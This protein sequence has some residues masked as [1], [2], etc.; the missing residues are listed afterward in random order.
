MA[1][2]G[3]G[4]S[5][6][7]GG[8]TNNTATGKIAGPAS[9]TLLTS[10]TFYDSLSGYTLSYPLQIAVPTSVPT[11]GSRLNDVGCNYRYFYSAPVA[12]SVGTD[13]LFGSLW[14]LNNTK[15]LAP[16]LG[17]QAAREFEDVR[18]LSAWTSTKGEGIRVA[19]IDDAIEITHG[20]L[21]PNVEPF[22]SFDYSRQTPTA[23]PLPCKSDETH[24]TAVAG[25]LAARDNNSVGIAGV[26]P[27]VKMSAFN[28]L[29]N[30]LDS[31]IA[32]ALNREQAAISIYH[33]SWGSADNGFLHAS[34]SRY[35]DAIYRGVR[36]GRGGKGSIYV[37]PAGNG[38]CIYEFGNSCIE[39]NSNFDA[40]VNNPAVIAVCAVDDQGVQPYYGERG[41]NILVCA[42]SSN[43]SN[44]NAISTLAVNNGTITDFGGTSASTPMVSGVIALMLS[45][46]PNLTWRDVRIILAKTARKN[47]VTDSR[48]V[49]SNRL[50]FNDKYGFG[51]V[52]AQAAVAQAKTWASV[53]TS[54][55]LKVCDSGYQLVNLSI[56]DLQSKSASFNVNCPQITKIEFIE[57]VFSATHEYSG[58]LKIELTSPSLTTS[59][60]ATPRVCKQ[61]NADGTLYISTQTGKSITLPCGDYLDWT[62]GSVR[63][64]EEAASGNWTLKVTDGLAQGAGTWDSWRIKIHGR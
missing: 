60:L 6:S 18:A 58:D 14:H 49:T 50:N 40:Y 1:C 2:G 29:A 19:V 36:L 39:E 32:D 59:E 4:G 54:T 42:P 47:D 43:Y 22:T 46:N 16:G 28:A 31:D 52:D 37:F 10:K 62:F 27:R 56:P 44:Q 57:V 12:A 11:A 21:A 20:D 17:G 26:S 24:G 51:V 48:W 38:G 33:N 15:Q 53:G 5:T 55:T 9:G 41:A 7:A 64:L 25:V 3:S 45:A 8:S 23:Y 13:P 34:D 30:R 63:H 35:L 61:L